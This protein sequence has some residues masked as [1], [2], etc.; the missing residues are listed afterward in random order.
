M[1]FRGPFDLRVD[2]AG[3]GEQRT[4]RIDWADEK[5]KLIEVTTPFEPKRARIDPDG[6]ILKY[7]SIDDTEKDV[8]FG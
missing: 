5:E 6:W 4:V 1:I 3:E 2:G 7:P 8:S